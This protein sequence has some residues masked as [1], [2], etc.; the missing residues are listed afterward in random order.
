MTARSSPLR[1][2]R[3]SVALQIGLSLMLLVG[4]GLFVRTLHNLKSL[5]AGFAT[6]HLLTFGIDPRMA[7][8]EPARTFALY[9]RVFET[10]KGLPGV[11]SVA[12]TNDPELANDN[13]TG[14][15]AIAGY[16][17]KTDENMNVEQPNV[18][19]DY[20]TTLQMPLLAGRA[21]TGQDSAGSEKVVV[22]NESFARHFFGD[23]QQALGHNLG[24]GGK[25]K[26]TDVAIVGVVKDAKHSSL[27]EP[28]ARTVFRPYPQMPEPHGM[29]F[30]V[31]TWQQPESAESTIRRS[32]Q[33]LDSNLVLDTFRTMDEQI[34]NNLTAE[35]V[36]AFLASGFGVLAALMAAVGLYGVLAYSTTQRTSEI[37]IRMALGATRASVV[38][39]VLFEVLWLAG[40][41]I[42]VT[43]PVSLLL[44]RAVRSQLYGI[45]SS[46]PLT[47]CAMTLLVT[48]VALVSAMLSARRAARVDPMKALRYE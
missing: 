15:V 11:R 44:M 42:A 9:Q 23:P 10:L 29:T 21:F 6:D 16:S 7:G 1:F 18:S 13:E 43:L 30:Y 17:E 22:V 4:A 41:S 33:T 38:G 20:F 12:A 40:I 25:G 35:R 34:D 37:G 3:V 48:F 45:S 47:L 46:D 5:N 28:V 39:M 36:I 24:D 26:K 2:R 32:M 14:D 27:R 31:R 19:V 8:Y